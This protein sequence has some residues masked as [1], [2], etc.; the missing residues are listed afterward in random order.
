MTGQPP[1]SRPTVPD[2]ADLL[3]RIG[4]VRAG[5]T[6]VLPEGTAPAAAAPS[7]TLRPPP[8]G[9]KR[10]TR[11]GELDIRR[12]VYLVT[13]FLGYSD[14][15]F[16]RNAHIAILKRLPYPAEAKRRVADLRRDGGRG[17][18]LCRLRFSSEG[19]RTGVW[20]CFLLPWFG[21]DLLRSAV[22]RHRRP[23]ADGPRR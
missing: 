9:E 6:E 15:D 11:V 2:A 8:P 7:T 5:R 14:A 12:R 13:E 4:R 17:A 21:I 23:L 16:V 18:L 22:T 10:A 20:L 19:R 1:L 3:A